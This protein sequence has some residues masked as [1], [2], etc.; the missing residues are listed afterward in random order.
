MSSCGSLGCGGR[1]A[2][3]TTSIPRWS[4][5]KADARVWRAGR[6]SAASGEESGCV[7]DDVRYRRL[8]FTQQLAFNARKEFARNLSKGDACMDLALAAVHIAAEDDALISISPVDFPVKSYMDRIDRLATNLGK[9]IKSALPDRLMPPE[10]ALPLVEKCLFQEEKF[11]VPSFGKSN[12][13]EGTVVDHPGVWEDQKYAYMNEL[14]IR[15]VGTPALVTIL[16]QDIMKRL[17]RMEAIDFVVNMD[18]QGFTQMPRAQVLAGM[19]RAV[20]LREDGVMLNTCSSDALIEVLQ[21]L[22]RAFWPFEWDTNEQDGGG[23]RGAVAMLVDGEMSSDLEAISRTAKH[24]LERGIFTTTGGGDVRRA[25][26]ACERLAML[27]G[28]THPMERRDLAVLLSH[29]GE[30]GRAGV[31]L[32]CYMESAAFQSGSLEDKLP[33]QQMHAFLQGF[34]DVQQPDMPMSV[35]YILGLDAPVLDPERRISLTW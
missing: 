8:D 10:Q 28:D 29:V 26:I 19:D 21:F 14:L 9:R 12:I 17:L 7:E 24:R 34:E 2:I 11:K 33:V 15:R 16:Y 13:P 30:I 22:K 3:V 5:V 18:C 32:Q 27:C 4:H 31:E 23:F 35:D 20:V 6:V 1:G 25:V